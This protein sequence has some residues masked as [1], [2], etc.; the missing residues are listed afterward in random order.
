MR[1]ILSTAAANTSSSQLAALLQLRHRLQLQDKTSTSLLASVE[2]RLATIS[3]VISCT[4]QTPS[5]LPQCQEG[6]FIS[7][8]L[9]PRFCYWL[10]AVWLWEAS[11]PL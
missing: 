10:R 2:Q 3:K 9:M 4:L 8:R 6:S 7:C 1:G 11:L 5:R